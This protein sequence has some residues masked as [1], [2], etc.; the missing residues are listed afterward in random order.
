M[1]LKIAIIGA[2]GIAER[3]YFPLLVKWPGVEIVSLFSRT[4]QTMEG[5]CAKWQIQ[6]GTTSLSSILESRPQAAFVLTSTES[7]YDICQLLLKNNI[8][9]Y[10]E[11]SLTA[12]SS[13]AL[14]L[15][16]L[17][18]D[19]QRILC[20]GFNRRYA[21]LYR[22]AKDIFG[23]RPLLSAIFQKHRPQGSQKSLFDQ[24]LD[25]TIH[26]ID[27]MRFFCG[28]LQPL[29]TRYEIRD[30]ILA[31]AVST[32]RTTSGGLV[33]LINSLQAGSWQESVSLHGDG[34]S[35]HVDA[36]REMRVKYNDHE[37][38]YGT[39]RAGNWTTDMQERGFE[40]EIKH[41]FECVQSRQT[42]L[43]N[44][45]EAA[46]TQELMEKLVRTSGDFLNTPKD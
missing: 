3:A 14:E 5:A 22:Q 26:Q 44:A 4:R 40:G 23:N 25:D 12:Y 11:K 38:I 31:S 16:R 10:A 32:A 8:D 9:V 43:T 33:T 19:R 36:F 30:G 7:H 24:Y 20:V 2:G 45:R 28:E 17:A 15:A 18:E 29:D 34:F 39:D 13:Q 21:L 27:L 41:F 1:S 37:E 6:N 35:I 42:P 46:K